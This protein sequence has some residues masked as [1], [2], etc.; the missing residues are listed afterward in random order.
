MKS[1][2][3]G[4]SPGQVDKEVSEW[5]ISRQSIHSTNGSLY[6]IP[7]NERWHIT[8]RISR[9]GLHYLSTAKN[10][11]VQVRTETEKGNAM[12]LSDCVWSPQKT[13]T[14]IIAWYRSIT[15]RYESHSTACDK[16]GQAWTLTHWPTIPSHIFDCV[17]VASYGG[18]VLSS[19]QTLKIVRYPYQQNVDNAKRN[20]LPWPKDCWSWSP[21]KIQWRFKFTFFKL[22][23]DT[24][25]VLSAPKFMGK[26]KSSPA[27]EIVQQKVIWNLW[28][29][30]FNIWNNSKDHPRL[31]GDF[32]GSPRETICWSIIRMIVRFI[33]YHTRVNNWLPK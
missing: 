23:S 22:L 24:A 30:I 31:S 11:T 1:R 7:S 16:P 29:E 28:Q 27:Q 26:T 3:K 6:Y 5:G 14:I 18:I 20:P 13:L 8:G 10:K 21:R 17:A 9:C 19:T 32:S 12:P 4:P 15:D 2:S 33:H 25:P